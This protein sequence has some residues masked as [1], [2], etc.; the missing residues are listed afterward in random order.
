MPGGLSN[1]RAGKERADDWLEEPPGAEVPLSRLAG[2]AE[3]DLLILGQRVT[4]PLTAKVAEADKF[5]VWPGR[6]GRRQAVRVESP[7]KP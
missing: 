5:R 2:L 7:V 3:G 6:V 1:G 4:D